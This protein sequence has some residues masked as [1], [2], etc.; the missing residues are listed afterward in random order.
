MGKVAEKPPRTGSQ[1]NPRGNVVTR[2]AMLA[3]RRGE[4]MTCKN[5]D[6]LLKELKS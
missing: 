2:A 4:G 1:P 3:A 5:A 6:E